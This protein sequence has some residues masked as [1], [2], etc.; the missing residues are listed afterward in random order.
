M[1]KLIDEVIKREIKIILTDVDG[2][3]TD[4]SINFSANGE[5]FYSFNAKDGHAIYEA[6]KK[7]IIVGI[8]TRWNSKIVEQACMQLGIKEVYQN[9][10]DKVEVCKQIINSHRLSFENV[11]YMGD[12][13]P[14]LELLKVVGFSGAPN[15]AVE[16]VK[17]NVNFISSFGG[18][19]GA[20]R[21][22]V[23]KIIEI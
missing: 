17:K 9:V 23:E 15:D 7:G 4:G 2:V 21:E 11:A 3:L 5:M 18:G 13:I 19:K 22:F 12:D 8:I 14:D 16:K 10:N 20:F 6:I 1:N